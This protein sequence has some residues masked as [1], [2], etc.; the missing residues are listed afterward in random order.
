MPG[1]YAHI[2][3]VNELKEPQRLEAVPRFPA[4]AISAL[5]DYFKF[6]ELGAVSPDY[7]YLAIGDGDAKKWADIMHYT[8]TGHVI[9]A[10]VKRLQSLGGETQRKCLAWL[11]GYT[12][13]VTTD[14]TIHPVVE[15][16][17]GSYQGHEKAHRIC[18]MHQDAYI[19]QRLNLGEVGVS[20]HLDSGIATCRDSADPD[21]LD[22]DIVFLWMGMMRDVHPDEFVN[23]PP[24][25]DKWHRGF[26]FGIGK[27]AEEG[28]HLIPLARH[29]AVG[30]GL[31]Y[32]PKEDVD[33][34]YITGLAIPGG[35]RMDYDA[36]FADAIRNVA[37]IWQ[38]VASGAMQGR[39]TYLSKIG[40]W[41]LDTGR[42]ES[43]RL[44]FWGMA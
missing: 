32:P 8:Q 25:I 17:V 2:T 22:R 21:L 7:P 44:V 14:M 28:Y 4:E 12:A 15:L 18:E 13:H 27:I 29:V 1:A 43:M 10:G 38:V 31:T 23:N 41:N 35:K 6:C 39:Q 34:Q 16:K 37:G 5:L 3:L 42:D 36:I 26:K 40:D 9:Q 20:E 11:M 19:F 30:E 24:D 33:Q